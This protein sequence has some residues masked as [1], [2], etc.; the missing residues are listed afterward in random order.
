M[1]L[2]AR[3]PQSIPRGHP[4]DGPMMDACRGQSAFLMGDAATAVVMRKPWW[5]ILWDAGVAF[6][7]HDIESYMGSD[8]SGLY[9][10]SFSVA[11]VGL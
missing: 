9:S 7:T 4:P 1:G 11:A 8:H 3:P 5:K 6:G 10:L 2:S